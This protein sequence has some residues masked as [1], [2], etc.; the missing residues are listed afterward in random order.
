MRVDQR[1]LRSVRWVARAPRLAVI[2]TAV[3]LSVAG[4]RSIA[5]PQPALEPRRP[6]APR[7]D[8][9]AAGFAEAFAR[10]YLSWDDER[11]DQR[12][13]ALARFMADTAEPGADVRPQPGE[14]QT[15]TAASAVLQER[16]GGSVRVTVAVEVEGRLL[17]LVV[18]VR[19]DRQGLLFVPA[20]PAIVGGPASTEA[21]RSPQEDPVEDPDLVEVA[22]RACR[23]YVARERTNLI[24]DL[25]DDAVV[26]LP[27]ADLRVQSVDAVTWTQ[28]PDRVAVL[29]DAVSGDG[30]D[31]TLR[32]EL[33]VA[34]SAGRWLV[35]SIGT[36]PTS[37][38]AL[39]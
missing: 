6:A 26:A 34:R 1:S 25:A 3:V 31:M 9:A 28:P 21:T 30:T 19:R 38:E 36:N 12:D 8:L 24:A 13:R 29:V 11:P 32:Y 22:T 5:A 16:H 4:V 2:G 15:V 20:P 23:N 39:R 10:A 33:E 27:D 37:T 14:A 7:V 35:R 18:P 17:Y